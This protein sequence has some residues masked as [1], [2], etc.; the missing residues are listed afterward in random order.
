MRG[1]GEVYILFDNA[2]KKRVIRRGEGLHTVTSQTVV[3]RLSRKP[4]SLTG[5]TRATVVVIT[6]LIVFSN[7]FSGALTS[8][9]SV[10]F[11]R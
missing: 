8:T 9:R 4:Y 1:W 11:T 2:E 6:S 10:S 5:D 3:G 7:H